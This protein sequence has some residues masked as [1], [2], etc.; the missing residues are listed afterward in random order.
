LSSEQSYYI[1]ENHA[2]MSSNKY[3]GECNRP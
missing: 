1:A 2:S 3:R